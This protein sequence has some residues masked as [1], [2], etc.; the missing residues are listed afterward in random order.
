MKGFDKD[1]DGFVSREEFRSGDEV[2]DQT[3]AEEMAHF[4]DL[5]LDLDDRLSAEEVFAMGDNDKLAKDEVT[6]LLEVCDMDKD[7]KLSIEE[8]VMQEEELMSSP[9]TDYGR[10]I[11]FVKDEF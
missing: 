3:R 1:G 8:I 2:D 9:A 11:H 6:H 7:G 5:D 4:H 10:I